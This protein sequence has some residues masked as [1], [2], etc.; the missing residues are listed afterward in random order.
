M[1]RVRRKVHFHLSDDICE[2]L[3]KISDKR[4]VTKV[5]IIRELIIKEAKKEKVSL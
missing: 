2:M 4:D 3:K 5:A 1:K